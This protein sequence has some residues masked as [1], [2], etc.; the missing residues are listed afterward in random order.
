MTS[1][2]DELEIELEAAPVV[3]L[4][5]IASL[6]VLS[7]EAREA[8]HQLQAEERQRLGSGRASSASALLDISSCLIE[9][10]LFE[11][12]GA[13]ING[14]IAK[15]SQ[16]LVQA[17]QVA[18]DLRKPRQKWTFWT[19]ERE[20]LLLSFHDVAASK[21]DMKNLKKG[22]FYPRL[23]DL[24]PVVDTFLKAEAYENKAGET[25][26]DFTSNSSKK[27]ADLAKERDE[28]QKNADRAVQRHLR[29]LLNARQSVALSDSLFGDLL[30]DFLGHLRPEC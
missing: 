25:I 17:L 8:V 7:T 2:D 21:A 3:P 18:S 13:F 29:A 10:G 1:Q 22:S 27:H 30:G 12:H 23:L 24:W 19:V 16:D 15:S 11:Q 4:H 28:F 6:E 26:D 14:L 9:H 20:K 5:H